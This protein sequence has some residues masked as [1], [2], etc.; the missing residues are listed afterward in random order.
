MFDIEKC[1]ICVLKLKETWGS[2]AL[3]LAHSG[4][5]RSSKSEITQSKLQTLDKRAQPSGVLASAPGLG[6]EMQHEWPAPLPLQLCEQQGPKQ[7]LDC[8]LTHCWAFSPARLLSVPL[9]IN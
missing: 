7:P 3:A 5:S 2:P 4:P 8:A 1:K 9:L 6:H